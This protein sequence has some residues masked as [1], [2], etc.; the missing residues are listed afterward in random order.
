MEKRN[1]VWDWDRSWDWQREVEENEFM[2][3]IQKTIIRR[4]HNPHYQPFQLDPSFVLKYSKIKPPFGF[5]GLGEFVYRRTYSR[6]KPDGSNEEWYETVARI[7]NGVY[8]M[9]KRWFEGRIN[10]SDHK[11]QESAQEMYDRIFN[12]KFLPPGRG[13]WAMGTEITEER[14]L[15]AA[16]NNCA[17]VST[18]NLKEDLSKPFT[19]LMDMSMLGVGVGFDTLGAGKL[20]V[21]GPDGRRGKEYFKIPDTREGW[22]ESVRRLLESYFLGTGRIEFDYSA[23][24]PD[25]API[26][27]FGGK[28]CGAEPLRELHSQIEE[29]LK[30]DLGRE[31]SVTSIVDIQNL[32]GRCVVAG[33]VRRTAEIAFGDP[34]S[35][36]FLDLKDYRINPQR[37]AWGWASNNSVFAEL[38][39]DYS[40]IAKRIINNGEPG[41]AWLENMRA[42]GRFKDGKNYK[43]RRA[44][45]GNPCLEQTLES[46]ELC[47]LVETFPAKHDSLEDFK[48]T[49]KFA[50]LY[51]KTVSL[52]ETHW[53]ET[54]A[55][56]L[57]NR[58]IGCSVSGIANFLSRKGV[59]ELIKWLEEGY[60]TVQHYDEIYSEWFAIPRSIKTT[61]VKPSGSVSLLNGSTPGLHFPISP[62]YIRRVRLSKN[63]ELVKPLIEAGY[64]VEEDKNNPQ[65]TLV[66]EF[67]VFVGE[68]IRSESEVSMW[69]QLSLASLLQEHWADNQVSCTI[70]FDPEKEGKDIARALD[71]FQWKL[72]GVSF[73]PLTKAE[74]YPQMPYQP[75]TKE[76]YNRM[77][78]RIKPLDFSRVKNDDIEIERFC[79][80]D[81]CEIK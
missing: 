64:N 52:G 21:K 77:L 40:E 57:R 56:L 8:N 23:I 50:Y 16:L 7:V 42:Y 72:K 58:R 35:E 70:K 73:L 81:S 37:A 74:V 66:V 26:K 78:E 46:Y 38:G 79:N 71:F 1:Y 65:N 59:G 61:S 33:N 28:S 32:I 25:G 54:N 43:D 12:M 34:R 18:E 6:I 48:R 27:G 45:G 29:I 24:R 63:S 67:P 19:F 9:Q 14:G 30:R 49:L 80:N 41:V 53:P 60:Q 4:L 39:M 17:F 47:N 68:N 11:A 10:W 5:N 75:I 36:E 51:A 76:E 44:K 31:I 55:I 3:S 22:V 15:Y 20:Y 69:E 13:L 62:Y 2:S